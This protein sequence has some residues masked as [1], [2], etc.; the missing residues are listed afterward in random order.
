[1][2]TRPPSHRIHNVFHDSYLEPYN[3]RQRGDITPALLPPD[4]INEV[5][6]ILG[7]QKRKGELRYKI[8]WK[9]YPTEYDHWIPGTGHDR[10]TRV[11][12]SVQHWSEEKRQ[13]LTAVNT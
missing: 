5:E 13:K 3:Q 10:C 8:R 1:M 6:E 4:L 12:T 9:G 11:A 2:W 7:R